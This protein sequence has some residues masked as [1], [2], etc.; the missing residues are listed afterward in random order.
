M[1]QSMGWQ[2]VGHDWTADQQ[3]EKQGLAGISGIAIIIGGLRHTSTRE[4]EN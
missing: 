2:R 3:P 1:L 4:K